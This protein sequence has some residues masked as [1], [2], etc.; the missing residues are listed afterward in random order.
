MKEKNLVTVASR[1][2]QEQELRQNIQ[3]RPQSPAEYYRLGCFFNEKGNLAEAADMLRQAISLDSEAA[4]FYQELGLVL[5][6]AGMLE[7]AAELLRWALVLQP[8]YP[9][10]INN[11]G[12]ILRRAGESEEAENCFRR[13]LL[14]KPCFADAYNNLGM[15]LA[16]DVQCQAESL[17]CFRKAVTL[18]ATNANIQYNLGLALKNRHEFKEAEACLQR[19]LQLKEEFFEADF[20]LAELYLLQ[21]R[22]ELGWDRYDALRLLERRQGQLPLSHWQGERLAGKKIL[23]Y[24]DQGYGDSLQFL[25]Y[26]PKVAEMAEEVGVLVQKPLEELARQSLPECRVWDSSEMLPLQEYDLACPLMSLPH[27]FHTKLEFLP[28]EIPYV[29][30]K[31]E[32]AASWAKQL[33]QLAPQGN[34]RIGVVW[35]GN[36]AHS[37]DK[38]RSVAIS[39]LMPLLEQQKIFWLSLQVGERAKDIKKLPN[40]ADIADISLQ[41]KDFAVTAAVIANLDLVL[42]VDSAVAHLAGAM[43]KKTWLMLPFNPDWRW[44]LDREDSPWYPSMRLFR[45]KRLGDW[46]EVVSDVKKALEAIGQDH[47]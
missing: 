32:E 37:N 13:A 28:Q 26:A 29:Q 41:L 5:G 1:M 27:W 15:V 8:E 17:Q 3:K 6:K 11:L 47:E 31:Q 10:A 18:E 45:Q 23:L 20:S 44:L 22:Y 30:P 43:G 34:F 24:A 16:E 9:E 35:A 46:T 12:V 40:Q 39:H 4:P 36:A 42:T 2:K 14:L 19:A 21:G 25:R 33:Q 7:K 38:N